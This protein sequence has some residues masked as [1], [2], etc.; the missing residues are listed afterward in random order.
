MIINKLF[1]V[2]ITRGNFSGTPHT[3]TSLKWQII[4]KYLYLISH[5]TYQFNSHLFALIA[6]T[7]GTVYR[8]YTI[9]VVF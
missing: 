9:H 6:G 4:C 2:A 3:L 8:I 5:L 1:A 7:F